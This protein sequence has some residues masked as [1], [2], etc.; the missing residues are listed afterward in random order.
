MNEEYV[1]Y[2]QNRKHENLS[3]IGRYLEIQNYSLI[4]KYIAQKQQF[5]IGKMMGYVL[6]QSFVKSFEEILKEMFKD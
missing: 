6:A 4:D 3:A 5:G 2:A 1:R